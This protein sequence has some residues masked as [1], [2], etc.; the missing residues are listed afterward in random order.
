MEKQR[1]KFL[2]LALTSIF[3]TASYAQESIVVS[4][5]TATG[6]GGASSY[7]IGQVIYGSNSGSN[8]SLTQGVQQSYEIITLGIDDFAEIN[9]VMS[10]YPNPTVDVLHLVVSDDKWTDLSYQI[11]DSNGRTLSKLQEITAAET[12]LLMQEKS[13]GIYFVAISNANKTLKTFKIVKN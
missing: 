3:F 4:G 5:G 6:S 13:H 8:G 2:L 1:Q 12:L 11:F 9:L 7:S 10:A